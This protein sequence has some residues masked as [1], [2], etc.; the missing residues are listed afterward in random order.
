MSWSADRFL[1]GH[2]KISQSRR[3]YRF[4]IDAVILAFHA[5]PAKLD[6]RILD[7][8]TGCGIMPL[9]I[10]HR[11]EG[12]HVTG[13]EIQPELA[14]LARQNVCANGFQ[15]R[16][17]ILEKDVS[18]MRSHDIGPSV[19]MVITNPP[20]RKPGSGRVN[21]QN[22]RAL[23]RHEIT[24]SLDGMVKAMRRFLVTGGSGW[25]IYPVERVAELMTAMQTHNL[26]PK[27]LRLIH[28][29]ID[30]EAK[31]CLLKIVKAARPGLI[32][33]P[34]LAIYDADGA[35]TEE[36]AAMFCP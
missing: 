16:I 15:S 6:E 7:M 28:S 1:N 30:T 36:V 11:H 4:S 23:A 8:G 13:V 20:Y 9:I 27:Y 26:E 10:A 29:R 17:T 33:G 35:Y 12:V 24:L 34:P 32:A 21:P 22:Q 2:L 3:G 5:V 31:R 25:I 18:Q 19:D 14:E